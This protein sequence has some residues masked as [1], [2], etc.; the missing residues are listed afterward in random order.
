M[1]CNHWMGEEPYDAER[2]KEIERAIAQL[3]CA[4][5]DADEAAIRRGNNHKAGEA[6]DAAKK[7][8]L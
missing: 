1:G 6:I 7:I 5:L 2:A 8:Y 4:E 3:R